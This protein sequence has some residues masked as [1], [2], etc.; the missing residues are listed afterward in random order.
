VQ[1]SV[2]R[3]DDLGEPELGRRRELQLSTPELAS[4]FVSSAFACAVGTISEHARVAV[5][6]GRR[7]AD[8]PR[9]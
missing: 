6:A 1:A 2:I 8:R 3:P 4:P 9:L 5:V 7:A